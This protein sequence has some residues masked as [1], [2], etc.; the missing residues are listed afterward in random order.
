MN[1]V[2]SRLS[3]QTVR[4][5]WPAYC[6]AFV[7]LASGVVLIATTVNLIG[8]VDATLTDLG[9]AAT[10][11]QRQQL[12]DLT[13]MFG[14]MSAVSLFMAIFVVGS[15]FGF[16][17]ATRRRELGLLRLIGA[18]GR[19]VRRLVLGESVVVAAGA[20][21]VGCLI[22]TPLAA[23]VLD[24]VRRLG[25]TDLHLVAPPAWLAW[26]IAAPSGLVVALLGAWRSSR[27]AARIPPSAALREAAIERSRPSLL[28]LVVGSLCLATV[29][30]ATV[31]TQHA[32]P[33]FVLVASVLLP[34]VIVI[35]VM[36]FGTLLVPRLAA[37]LARPFAGRDV[38]ARLARDELRA[39]VR[40]TTS[41]A[42]PVIAISAI[43]GSML[44]A[45]SF[46]ADWTSAQD[47]AQLHAPLVVR[48]GA[49]HETEAATKLAQN[50]S[51]KLV[52]ARR[53]LTV[54]FGDGD[55]G[56]E[57]QE[58]D[59][60]DVTTAA[61]ARGLHATKGNLSH[62]HGPTAAVSETQV[63]DAGIG[64]GGHLR[65]QVDGQVVDLTIVAVVPAAPDLYG[66]ILLPADLVAK[67]LGNAPA[68]ELFVV[69]EPGTETGV[70]STAL[71]QDLSSTDSQVL[72]SEEW[73]ADT[74][75]QVRRSNNF[76]LTILLGPAG[77]Y[78]AIAVVNATLI[79][80]TQRRR[81]HRA[82]GLLGATRDQLRRTALWQAAL[83]TG[84]GLVLGGL[85]TGFLGWLV[86]RTVTADLA[87]TGV[88]ASMTIPWL[89]LVAIVLACVGL[90]LTA[91][92][93][94]AIGLEKRA[95]TS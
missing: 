68:G 58:V 22:A 70:A 44:L 3:R 94:G 31:L 9:G 49:G 91:A 18:T 20:V 38:T 11:E 51:V 65:A 61:V 74:T 82:L 48:P 24:L 6:G 27:R 62:L 76:G 83:I 17:V 23:P 25:L 69:L 33:L 16:V 19:Q 35:G 5:S 75:D 63:I 45:L 36:C 90:A 4:T 55:G 53:L 52:D 78:A 34:E 30:I 7:A 39:A 28:Q 37:L 13:S 79:G 47:R 67:D 84:A 87:G 14:I 77:F 32:E 54:P 56:Y 89:P 66:E 15:T 26:A 92:T 81:Q 60:V 42:A 12:D 46:T 50:P 59:A 86:R 95:A 40:T 73:I 57:R 10:Q 29:A 85:T 80:A 41:V 21:I 93:A 2:M 88:D 43:A 1:P 8:S 71:D 72:T 64:L